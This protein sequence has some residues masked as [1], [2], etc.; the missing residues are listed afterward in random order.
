MLGALFRKK[1]PKYVSVDIGSSA[2]KLMELETNGAK[3]RL[4]NAGVIPTPLESIKNN[5]IV[6][7]QD[8]AMAIR[9][10]LDAN[11]IEA[12]QAVTALPGPAVFTKKINVTGSTLKEL[13]S[14]I[15]YE[16]GNYIPH[17]IGAVRLDFQVLKMNGESNMDVLLVA[18]KNEIIDSYAETLALAGLQPMIADVDY[19]ALE[20]MFEINYP[21]ERAKTIA[22]INIGA[23]YSAINIMQEGKSLFTGDVGVGGK[24]WSDALCERFQI[25]NTEAEQVKLSGPA[26]GMEQEAYDEVRQRSLEHL[27]AEL[28]RQVGF[29]WN[30]ASTDRAIEAIYLCGG[31]AQMPGLLDEL[32][33]RTRV[34]CR[35]IE[36]FR[37]IQCSGDFDREFLNEISPAMC[38]SVGLATRRVGDKQHELAE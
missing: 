34:P 17:N 33:K 32:S 28:Q 10:L 25:K 9:S 22:V 31:G 20:N 35:L 3:P 36:A 16:A 37:G 7:Q 27:A 5:T 23:R 38:V 11:G 29:F 6:R 30:A 8:V 15:E 26:E 14:N 2:I 19:F 4:R 24:L 18:V 21:E 13:S 12:T 1:D